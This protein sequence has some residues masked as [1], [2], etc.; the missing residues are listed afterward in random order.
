M[1]FE[2]ALRHRV[3]VK[4][5]LVGFFSVALHVSSMGSTSLWASLG[6]KSVQRSWRFPSLGGEPT[7]TAT[8]RFSLWKCTDQ[9]SVLPFN[10]GASALTE[11]H[12]PP[13]GESRKCF[14]KH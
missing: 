11:D 8:S 10:T 12:L 3:Y 6:E 7:K 5:K 14:L 13:I 1:S 9:S 4:S 2:A